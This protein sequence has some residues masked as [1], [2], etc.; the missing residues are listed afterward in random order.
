MPNNTY[1]VVWNPTLNALPQDERGYYKLSHIAAPNRQSIGEPY[2][3]ILNVV[4]NTV[5]PSVGQPWTTANIVAGTLKF[6]GREIPDG[7]ANGTN[8]IFTLA[9]G[10]VDPASFSGTINDIPLGSNPNVDYTLSGGT[11][12]ILTLSAAPAI[13]S[14]FYVYYAYGTA[15]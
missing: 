4:A 14:E 12:Q 10:T 5:S 8:T 13:N 7:N 2:F 9:H 15:I 1:G 6:S 11:N 3:R